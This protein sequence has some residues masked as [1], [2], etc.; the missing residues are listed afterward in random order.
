[1]QAD[2]YKT[3]FEILGEELVARMCDAFGSEPINFKA[4]THY[5]NHKRMKEYF[6][7]KMPVHRIASLLKVSKKM[8]RRQR[9]KFIY[10]K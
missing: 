7:K 3:V 4:A 5:L 6:E 10:G 8:V 9:D 2:K 1:M